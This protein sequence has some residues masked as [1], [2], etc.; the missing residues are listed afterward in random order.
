MQKTDI[1]VIC[2]E[3][4]CCDANRLKPARSEHE[5]TQEGETAKPGKAKRE[6]VKMFNFERETRIGISGVVSYEPCLGDLCS[7]M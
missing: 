4:G 1:M 3:D 6:H 7:C 5:R 2:E